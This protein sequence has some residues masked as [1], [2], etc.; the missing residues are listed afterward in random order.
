MKPSIQSI[1]KNL[2]ID[3]LMKIK[4]IYMKFSIVGVIL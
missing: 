2:E 4:K 3:F 1:S